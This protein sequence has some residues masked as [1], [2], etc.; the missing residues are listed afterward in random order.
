MFC[1]RGNHSPWP[2]FTS[3]WVRLVSG[4]SKVSITSPA[5]EWVRTSPAVNK[6]KRETAWSCI[7]LGSSS[8]H[9]PCWAPHT[10]NIPSQGPSASLVLLGGVNTETFFGKAFCTLWRF[11]YF[12]NGKAWN[13]FEGSYSFG[14]LCADSSWDEAFLV[15]LLSVMHKEK[16]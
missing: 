3:S 15:K 8:I 1:F 9:V 14:D 6:T 2:Q 10:A 12:L 11:L 5:P 4:W 7:D 13:S 16:Q